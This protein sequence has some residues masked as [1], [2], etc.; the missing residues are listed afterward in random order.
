MWD[1]STS[2]CVSTFDAADAEVLDVVASEDQ[3]LLFA[4]TYDAS[5]LVYNLETNSLVT[6]LHGHNWEVWK[7]A[8]CQSRLFSASFDHSIKRWDARMFLCDATLTG[9]K[10]FVHALQITPDGL[11]SGCADRT[12]KVW[13]TQSLPNAFPSALEVKRPAMPTRTL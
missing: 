13:P 1:V 4:S 6:T 5:I 9:H 8:V 12:I 2:Q 11:F 7:L 3:K 10:G